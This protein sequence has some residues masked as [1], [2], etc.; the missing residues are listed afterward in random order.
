MLEKV[1]KK[2]L[3]VVLNDYVSTYR[4]LL[5]NVSKPTLYVAR[6]KAIAIEAYKCYVNENPQYINAIFDSVDKPYDLR[7]GPGG[8]TQS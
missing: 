1:N 5:D 2:A 6:L 8:A 4:D 3:R 7:G